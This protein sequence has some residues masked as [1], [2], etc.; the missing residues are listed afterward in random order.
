VQVGNVAIPLSAHKV[1]MAEGPLSRAESTLVQTLNLAIFPTGASHKELKETSGLP[2]S[3]LSRMLDRLIRRGYVEQ[4]ARGKYA[5]TQTGRM[6]ALEGA[7]GAPDGPPSG[8]EFDLNWKPQIPRMI[9]GQRAQIPSNSGEFHS[10]SA[11]EAHFPPTGGP[12]KGTPWK[13]P[14]ENGGKNPLAGWS[15]GIQ[16]QVRALEVGDVD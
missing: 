9:S 15:P 3:T 2:P 13:K 10:N 6:A 11:H 16:K 7:R 14:P 8:V 1:A 4:V 12:Y 5:L